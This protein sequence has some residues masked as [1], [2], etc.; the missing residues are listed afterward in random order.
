MNKENTLSMNPSF[1][2]SGGVFLFIFAL[3]HFLFAGVIRPAAEKVMA[4]AGTASLSSFWVILKD[5]EQQ[6][7]ISLMLFC[8]FLMVY[9][10]W[11]LLDEEEIYS[12]DLLPEH[13]KDTPLNVDK[14][15]D[16]LSSTGAVFA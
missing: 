3:V 12:R 11:K 4:T 13:N 6:V 1:L 15:L 2:V 8:I 10:L 9:K 16:E 7:C 5:I 14:A